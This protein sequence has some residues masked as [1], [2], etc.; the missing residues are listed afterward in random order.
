MV[1]QKKNLCRDIQ[2]NSESLEAL[3]VNG[4]PVD[5][6]TIENNIVLDN[7]DNDIDGI[8]DYEQIFDKHTETSSFL[9]QNENEQLENAAIQEKLNFQN[10]LEWPS[11]GNEPLN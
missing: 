11:I 1:D 6:Q 4:V 9:P 8:D 7:L 5:L 2:V 3:P 10:K